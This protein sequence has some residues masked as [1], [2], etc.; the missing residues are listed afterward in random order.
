VVRVLVVEETAKLARLLARG[1]CEEGWQVDVA[2]HGEEAVWMGRAAAYDVI[3]LDVMLPD[4][5]GV[6]VCGRLRESRVRTPVLMLSARD[7]VADRVAAL[8]AGADDYLVKPFAFEELLARLRALSRR[9]PL[10]R[11]GGS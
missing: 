2:G 1:L 11:P 10:Q 3:V 4:L 7:A 9:V 8:D 5:D 6:A